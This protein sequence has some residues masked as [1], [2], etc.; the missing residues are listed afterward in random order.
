MSRAANCVDCS[1]EFE[2]RGVKQ[3]RCPRC[4]PLYA[5]KKNQEAKKA[6]RAANPN[7]RPQGNPEETKVEIPYVVRRLTDNEYLYTLTDLYD[8]RIATLESRLSRVETLLNGP[9]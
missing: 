3:I 8:K 1:V 5:L 4:Q 7:Y 2:S 6:A 9:F